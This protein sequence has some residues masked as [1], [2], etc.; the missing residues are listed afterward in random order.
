M[1]RDTGGYLW[2]AADYHDSSSQQK[3]WGR[4][5]FP[6]LNLRGDERVLDIGCGDGRL[7]VELSELVPSGAV[8]GI[9]SSPE[10]ISFARDSFPPEDYPNLSWQ[11]MDAQELSFDGEFD[12]AFSNAVLHWVPDQGLVL[13]GVER[14][15]KGGGRLLFQMGG[16]GMAAN[17]VQVMM[18]VLSRGDWGRFFHDF[19][20]PY[21]FCGPEEYTRWLED[22]GLRP[23]RVE[24]VPKDMTHEGSRGLTA[25]IRTT[26]LPL[27]QRLPEDLREGFIAAIVEGY[28]ERFP[29][30]AEGL[31]HVD[32]VRLEI[33]AEKA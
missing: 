33:E 12:V 25:W 24:L 32:A 10:M 1:S 15:L 23:L 4:E 3:K 21:R 22:A 8:V 7:T 2:D 27:T 9:D 5:L 28:V 6:K 30:D 18:S 17:V 31:V 29:P 14:S 11:V 26:W 16:R 13:R 20:L 19:A